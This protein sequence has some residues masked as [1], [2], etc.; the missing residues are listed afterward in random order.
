MLHVVLLKPVLGFIVLDPSEG[1]PKVMFPH[2][3]DE[4]QSNLIRIGDGLLAVYLVR[5]STSPLDSVPI[6]GRPLE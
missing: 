2:T 3:P 5:R 4:E 6:L 1:K